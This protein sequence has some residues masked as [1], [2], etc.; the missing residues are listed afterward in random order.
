VARAYLAARRELRVERSVLP[1]LLPAAVVPLYLRTLTR[2]GFDVFRDSTDVG[3]H[4]RQL[5]MLGAMIRR[6]V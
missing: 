4:R 3:V 6:R 1:A 5:A 2:P